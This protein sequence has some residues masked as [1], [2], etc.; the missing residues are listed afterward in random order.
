MG[1]GV[2]ASGLGS[3][4]LLGGATNRGEAQVVRLSVLFAVVDLARPATIP[5][6][7]AAETGPKGNSY[8][9]HL[10]K[11]SEKRF[12][13]TYHYHY[14]VQANQEALKA[15]VRLGSLGEPSR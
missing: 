14:W 4:G 15:E 3:R 8:H 1:K 5:R 6:A 13:I 7:R 12:P 2:S 9:F 11:R 10:Q